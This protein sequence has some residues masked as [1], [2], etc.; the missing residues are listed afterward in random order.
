M[1]ELY[2]HTPGSETVT[3]AV[4][5][6]S[7]EEALEYAEMEIDEEQYI[8][9][10]KNGDEVKRYFITPGWGALTIVPMDPPK[11]KPFNKKLSNLIN[12][13]MAVEE[14]PSVPG[15]DEEEDEE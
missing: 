9:I 14:L 4:G 2:Y 15:E 1:Y 3:F 5:L 7:E 6:P 8:A 12:F 11:G 10:V 13:V